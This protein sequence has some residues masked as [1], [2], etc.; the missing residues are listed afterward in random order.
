[1]AEIIVKRDGGPGQLEFTNTLVT[2]MVLVV[3]QL[4]HKLQLQCNTISL[5]A[6]IIRIIT[7]DQNTYVKS[8]KLLFSVYSMTSFYRKKPW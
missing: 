8:R 6:F 1:M 2:T 5:L 3:E 7:L 4:V